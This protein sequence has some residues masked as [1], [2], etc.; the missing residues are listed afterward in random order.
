M[1]AAASLVPGSRLP[2]WSA[3]ARTAIN[4]LGQQQTL[5][6]A[7]LGDLV[8]PQRQ[9]AAGL[10]E[11]AEEDGGDPRRHAVGDRDERG[12]LVRFEEL[13]RG[14]RPPGQI[15]G[16]VRQRTPGQQDP[17]LG[18]GREGVQRGRRG[19]HRVGDQG[20]RQGEQERRRRHSAAGRED[21][22]GE[23]GADHAQRL[24]RREVG[25]VR[26]GMGRVRVR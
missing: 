13:R 7:G 21:E 26:P 25:Q 5:V 1:V 15:A 18:Q 8:E 19:E 6:L 20:G 3:P 14:P 10:D 23:Q 9:L 4:A 2:T 17:V 11:P 16:G 24:V 22:G 12:A